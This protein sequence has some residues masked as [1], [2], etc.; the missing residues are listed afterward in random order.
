MNR[1]E[2][3]RLDAGDVMTV[4]ASEERAQAWERDCAQR[5]ETIRAVLRERDRARGEA[6]RLRAALTDAL[7][8]LEDMVGY[9]DPYFSEKWDHQGYIDRA[10]SALAILFE[11]RHRQ[12]DH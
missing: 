11:V 2:A 8:G 5:G 6:A 3:T 10:R 1:A 7:D 9:V 12:A 4:N